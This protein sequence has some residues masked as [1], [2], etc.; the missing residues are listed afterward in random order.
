[1]LIDIQ[2]TPI[3]TRYRLLTGSV[4]PRPIAWVSTISKDGVLN[5]A[6]F[7]FFNVVSSDPAILVFSPGF[8]LVMQ[9]GKKITVKKDTL[10]NIQET[11][12]FVVNVVTY[13]LA[14]KM[15][16]TSGEFESHI[17]EFEKAGVTAAPSHMVQPPRVAESPISMECSLYQLIEFGQSPGAGNLVMGEIK[18]MHIDDAVLKDGR[19]ESDALDLVG[20]LGGSFYTTTRDKFSLPRPQVE[21]V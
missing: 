19:L 5:L 18:C 14:E 6:P 8:K 11:G 13:A 4:M 7:S 1:M 17:N 16:L 15:N 12:E 3:E 9:D 21:P 10:K 2:K 20:R